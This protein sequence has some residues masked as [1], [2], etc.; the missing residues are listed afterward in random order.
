MIYKITNTLNNKIYIGGTVK[1]NPQERFREHFA[2][3]KKYM[4]QIEKM[5]DM[6]NI[7]KKYWTIEKIEDCPNEQL[8]ERETY[9]INKYKKEGY[10]M[11]NEEM[12]SN[13][14][15]KFYSYDLK[16]N[17]IIEYSSYKETGFNI[18][19]ISAILNKTIERVNNKD[20]QRKSYKGKL[21]SYENKPEVWKQLKS[22]FD[23]R[24]AKPRKIMNIE[25]GIVYESI[26]DAN[27]DFGKPRSHNSITNALNGR[28]PRG[29]G[30]HWKYVD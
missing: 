28:V 25:T 1:K 29:L 27:E 7:D 26:A 9:Y 23:N 24:K 15:S 10:D 14:Q 6:R 12:V 5:Q 30:Y 18:S 22:E 21:W 8:K 19:K 20:Y 13:L 16:T 4:S 2:H 11:Y 17:E 3:A